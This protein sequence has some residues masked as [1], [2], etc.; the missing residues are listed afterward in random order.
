MKR[1]DVYKMYEDYCEDNGRTPHGKSRF[2]EYMAD[3]GFV[4]KRFSDGAYYFK[5]TTVKESDFEAIDDT[6]TN[7]FEQMNLALS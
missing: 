3:K 4:F 1:S 7:P 6:I 5:D 2:W